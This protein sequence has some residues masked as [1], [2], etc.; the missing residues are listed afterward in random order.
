MSHGVALGPLFSCFSLFC[1]ARLLS[2][3]LPSFLVSVRLL[4]PSSLSVACCV[5]I[6][7]TC[8]LPAPPNTHILSLALFG[9]PR[10]RGSARTAQEAPVLRN[11]PST[12]FFFCFLILYFL[13]HPFL[14][15]D[16][17]TVSSET[18]WSP[19]LSPSIFISKHPNFFLGP[20]RPHAACREGSAPR[21]PWVGQQAAG[22]WVA[23][24]EVQ[25]LTWTPERP[26]RQEG[27]TVSPQLIAP[28][29][30]PP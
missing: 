26:L 1:D 8:P 9:S 5:R 7:A 3:L 12:F 27:A 2:P 23:G 13:I 20:P 30:A 21:G 22:R 28:E 18:F 6:D 11:G 4:D 14:S 17:L 10:L 29:A 24:R 15:T 25:L 16:L 19:H